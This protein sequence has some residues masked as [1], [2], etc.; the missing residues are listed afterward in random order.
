MFHSQ[1]DLAAVVYG[2]G[3]D[4]DAVMAA[5]AGDLSRQ[6]RRV[7][8]LIQVARNCEDGRL[9]VLVLHSGEMIPLLDDRGPEAKGCKLNVGQLLHA[10][11][12]VARALSDGADLLIINRFGKQER[13]G[14]GLAYLIERALSADIPVM[15]AIHTSRFADWTKFSERMSVK[16]GCNGDSLGTWWDSITGRAHGPVPQQNESVCGTAK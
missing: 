9:S 5:F 11:E 16:L 15:V 6:G 2:D 14:K 4:P 12:E 7:A 13:E 10:G 3:E 1:N 8:G